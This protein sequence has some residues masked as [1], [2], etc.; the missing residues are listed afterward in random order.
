MT[1]LRHRS[2]E[3][4]L[5]DEADVDVEQLAGALRALEVINGWLGGY[6]PSLKGV[7][8]LASGNTSELSLLDVG[9]GGGDTLVKIHAW[10]RHRGVALRS[11]GIELSDVSAEMAKERLRQA[12][13]DVAEVKVTNLFDLDPARE[14]FDIVHASLVLHHF[15]SDAEAVRALVHM[16][17]LA[18]RGVV[19]NDLHRHAVAHGSIRLLTRVLSQNPVLRN[20]APLS[21]RRGFTRRELVRLAANAGFRAADVRV[22]WHWAF[23]WL[24]TIRTDSAA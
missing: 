5:M 11:R 14:Q 8:Q 24:M 23:R 1:S 9:C 10:A 15:E 3:P 2:F 22:S 19:I 4:E 6:A 21:V 20:D 13:I 12:N 17:C 16:G 18:R 7:A